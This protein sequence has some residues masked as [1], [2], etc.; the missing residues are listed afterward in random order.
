LLLLLLGMLKLL[1]K[2]LDL[3]VRL[4][5]SHVLDQHRLG[6]D[7]EGVRPGADA[8]TNQFVC[9]RISLRSRSLGD[10][11]RQ[12]SQHLAFFWCHWFPRQKRRIPDGLCSIME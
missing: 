5:H 11:R 6:H 3:S 9:V 2:I 12:V 8:C 10:F 4:I 1:L 7:V